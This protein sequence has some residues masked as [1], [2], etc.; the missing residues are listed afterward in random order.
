VYGQ[1]DGSV[2]TEES[3]AEPEAETARIL[4]ET[5]L[6]LLTAAQQSGFPAVILRLAGIYGP[7]RG[8]WLRQYLKQE[9]RIEGSGGRILNMIHRDD[10]V[11]CVIAALERG[12][13]GE[14]YNAVDD[15]PVSQI[16]LFQWLADTLG[17]GLPPSAPAD[18][19]AAR[20][21][22]T[23]KRVTNRKLKNE[24]DYSFKYP[25]FRQGYAAELAGFDRR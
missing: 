25:T 8:Y 21:G 14:I 12:R 20:R 2:V 3:R 9:A 7:D 1:N 15:E 6:A 13:P 24:L 23:S 22:A 16:K 5:E 18:A 10:V 11:G 4:V 19:G 17:R